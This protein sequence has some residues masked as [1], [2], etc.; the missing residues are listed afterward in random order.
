MLWIV[1]LCKVRRLRTFLHCECVLAMQQRPSKLSTDLMQIC[2]HVALLHFVLVSSIFFLLPVV[3]V[4]G[5][6]TCWF[7]PLCPEEGMQLVVS[8]HGRSSSCAPLT[9]PAAVLWP[10]TVTDAVEHLSQISAH[11]CPKS[12]MEVDSSVSWLLEKGRDWIVPCG[13]PD[14]LGLWEQVLDIM[15]AMCCQ[16]QVQTSPKK[17]SEKLLNRRSGLSVMHN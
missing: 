16:L 5:W 17:Q 8:S 12:E 7:Q 11:Q 14:W 15:L 13:Y 2:S 9:T 6:D 1:N 3:Q 10:L 4:P